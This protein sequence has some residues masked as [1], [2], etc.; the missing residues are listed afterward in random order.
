[1]SDII[2]RKLLYAYNYNL[3]LWSPLGLAPVRV[4]F[5]F[6]FFLSFF[7]CLILCV[8]A[9]VWM[10]PE[11]IAFTL[12]ERC[13]WGEGWGWRGMLELGF[14]SCN[15]LFFSF[16]LSF[17]FFSLFFFFFSSFQSPDKSHIIIRYLHIQNSFPSASSQHKSL[18]HKLVWLTVAMLKTNWLLICLR[19]TVTHVLVP[20]G[21][22]KVYLIIFIKIWKSRNHCMSIK[23]AKLTKL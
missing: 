21:L 11:S 12:K 13:K 15:F 3:Y 5:L 10:T 2:F 19:W 9:C 6:F 20:F 1:M 4:F 7:V 22:S 16:F 18:N 8:S 17:F 23:Q 14:K